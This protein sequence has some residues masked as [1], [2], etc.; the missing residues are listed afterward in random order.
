MKNYCE[1][2][3]QSW[4]NHILSCPVCIGERMAPA[5]SGESDGTLTM[6]VEPTIL[7]EV[8]TPGLKPAGK[9]S[10][11]SLFNENNRKEE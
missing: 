10:Q 4:M 3:N 7:T 2:H 5:G 6:A 11:I 8:R 1:K 9:P